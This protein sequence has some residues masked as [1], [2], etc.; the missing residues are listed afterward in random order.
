MEDSFR[1]SWQCEGSGRTTSELCL[2]WDLSHLLQ[3]AAVA[4]VPRSSLP[5]PFWQKDPWLP[6]RPG[7]SCC[8]ACYYWLSPAMMC[9]PRC[10][11]QG[12]RYLGSRLW[13]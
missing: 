7:P 4:D 9:C 3:V 11:G 5:H 13:N 6:L 2:S 1:L 8:L 12:Q 10:P